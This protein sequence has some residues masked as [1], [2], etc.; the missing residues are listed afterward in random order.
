[1]RTGLFSTKPPFDEYCT[2]FRRDFV[3]YFADD[4]DWK[5]ADG[6]KR[7]KEHILKN[8]QKA[9]TALVSQYTSLVTR[10]QNV[11]KWVL[12]VIHGNVYESPDGSKFDKPGSVS[13]F[14][15]MDGLPDYLCIQLLRK[16]VYCELTLTA[17]SECASLKATARCRL[18]I[19]EICNESFST[20]YTEED[21]QGLIEAFP[22]MESEAEKHSALF[23]R[24]GKGGCAL[25]LPPQWEK[26][27]RSFM[28]YDDNVR[29]KTAVDM[30]SE[31]NVF[32]TVTSSST[33]PV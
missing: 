4:G 28:T 20:S 23:T 1:M 3:R 10:S 13:R 2:G 26:Q 19:I 25:H 27:M 24:Y 32:L 16:V 8:L 14:Q 7:F 15:K 30:I 18:K 12:K 11:W 9:S 17:M 6:K 33:L 22:S 5:K 21:W 31:V 29:K